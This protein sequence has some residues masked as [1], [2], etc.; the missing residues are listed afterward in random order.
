MATSDRWAA[1]LNQ[2][3][4]RE[5]RSSGIKRPS[6]RRIAFRAGISPAYIA[7]VGAGRVPSRP[8]V[9]ELARATMTRSDREDPGQ[10]VA[11]T[12]SFLAAAG[13]ELLAPQEG[14]WDPFSAFISACRELADAHR[15]P[16]IIHPRDWPAPDWTQDQVQAAVNAIETRSALSP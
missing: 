4:D 8:V 15:T 3:I 9:I 13:Y 5:A 6:Y 2:A 14:Q 10:A 16:L 12:N 7:N 11:H 1:C